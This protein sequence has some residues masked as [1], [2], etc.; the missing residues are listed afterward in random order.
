MDTLNLS[1]CLF[2]QIMDTIGASPTESGGIFALSGEHTIANYY[3]DVHAGTGNRFY[4]PSAP[5]ITNRVNEWLREPG[6]SFGG[7]IHS[8]PPGHNTLSPMDIV[9]AEMTLFQNRLSRIY[10]L[11]LCEGRLLGY[12]LLPQPGKG[13]A[14][15]EP[16]TVRITA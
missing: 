11:L 2:D 3:F 15:V 10:M 7:Y 14:S 4:R 13:H 8:H 5:Q 16:C 1:R 6:I 12:L 9:A